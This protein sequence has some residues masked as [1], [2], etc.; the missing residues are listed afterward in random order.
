MCDLQ[1]DDFSL[2]SEGDD[3]TMYPLGEGSDW[4][5]PSGHVREIET[6]LRLGSVAYNEGWSNREWTVRV[7][8]ESPTF[9]GRAVGAAALHAALQRPTTLTMTPCDDWGAPT[10]FH[11]WTASLD[12]VTDDL[13]AI[14]NG[15][16]VY[17]VKLT[18]DPF[19]KGE[20][21][22]SVEAVPGSYVS[23][24]VWDGATDAIT[25]W[26]ATSGTLVDGGIY[27]TISGAA[28]TDV[29]QV[30]HATFGINA[31]Q[32][33]LLTVDMDRNG[34]VD[35][36]WLY[37]TTAATWVSST[38]ASYYS[39]VLGTLN[40]RYYFHFPAGNYA[41]I[42]IGGLTEAAS[43]EPIKVYKVTLA[44]N[45]DAGRSFFMDVPGSAPTSVSL[46]TTSVT[47]LVVH[48]IP[49]VGE[50]AGYSPELNNPG[51]VTVTTGSTLTY[52]ASNLPEG[53]YDLVA[54]I[55]K[56]ASGSGPILDISWDINGSGGTVPATDAVQGSRRLFDTAGAGY[57]A[58]LYPTLIGSGITVP[59]GATSM[60]IRV[61]L[62]SNLTPFEARIQCLWLMYTGNP[63]TGLRGEYSIITPDSPGVV[64]IDS[65][66]PERPRPR[67]LVGGTHKG[68][69]IKAWGDHEAWP[70]VMKLYAANVVQG[71]PLVAPT[72]TASGYPAYQTFAVPDDRET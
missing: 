30:Q 26:S 61:Q 37:D 42:R 1:V 57:G 36:A 62:K 20:T 44:D 4:G 12:Y 48:T 15:R 19:G 64:Q 53:T 68:S 16:D 13:S 23:P 41:G 51:S 54:Q 65:P 39:P 28:S 38:S 10:W 33:T 8:V 72:V 40:S 63:L 17:V 22:F 21:P 27:M 29:Q 2:W 24:A 18:L 46:T 34:F 56:A 71:A 14:A 31:V 70:G 59:D 47:S 69:W 58:N 6:F 60:T 55:G 43:G 66:T 25:G 45:G 5:N 50:V 49:A 35:S 67:I 52:A 32:S 9:A 11:I 7:A 3:W